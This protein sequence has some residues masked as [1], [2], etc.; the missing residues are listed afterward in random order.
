MPWGAIISAAI[1]AGAS[2]LGGKR[3]DEGQ[4]EA[5]K[6]NRLIAKENREFQER[7]SSTAYQRS[8]A[9]LEAAGLNRILAYGS[10]AS[11]P[12]GS[13]AVMQSEEAGMGAAIAEAPSS[14]LAVTTQR[15][16][17]KLAK[18]QTGNVSQDTKSKLQAA[19]LAKS[20][21]RLTTAEAAKA[22]MMR[23]FYAGMHATGKAT[24]DGSIGAWLNYEYD[25]GAA[26]IKGG[27]NS[28]RD[29]FNEWRSRNQKIAIPDAAPLGPE[30]II[31]RFKSHGGRSFIPRTK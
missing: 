16:Q 27:L 23:D 25:R 20:Q 18:A 2:L 3:T 24:V 14:A 1:G 13:L 17:I 22:E 28:A 8:A 19:L 26:A 6:Q 5:N 31:D 4:R 11:T 9:D 29:A 10:P 7:M 12:S 21:T 15:Q 30:I